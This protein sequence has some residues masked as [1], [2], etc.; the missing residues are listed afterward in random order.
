LYFHIKEEIPDFETKDCN[1]LKNELHNLISGGYNKFTFIK[2]FREAIKN[3]KNQDKNKKNYFPEKGTTNVYKLG[4]ALI[5]EIGLRKFTEFI[6]VKLPELV[7]NQKVSKT[8]KN[9]S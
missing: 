2:L 1:D 9:K 5:K 6:E 4:E 3:S 7:K 8:K